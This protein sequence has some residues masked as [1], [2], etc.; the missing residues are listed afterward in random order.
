MFIPC[1]ITLIHT[2]VNGQGQC[3]E[4]FTE[5]SSLSGFDLNTAVSRVEEYLYLFFSINFTCRAEISSFILLARDINDT[6][7][8]VY[9]LI[10]I[11]REDPAT[12]DLYNRIH[13]IG[14]ISE[15]SFLGN[16][17]YQY[18]PLN[19]TITVLPGDFLGLSA[20]S[21]DDVKISPFLLQSSSP[22]YYEV[23][24]ALPQLSQIFANNPNNFHNQFSPL[25]AVELGKCFFQ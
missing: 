4:G 22:Q 18:T 14:N 5:E 8:R 10:Q 7:G 16:S 24:S 23:A 12:P 25:I 11:W 13:N 6:Q 2:L 21:Y 15:V 20:P 17:S 19:G 3:P 9:P 1:H